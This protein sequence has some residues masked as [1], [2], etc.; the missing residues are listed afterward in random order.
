MSRRTRLAVVVG[1]CAA[2]AAAAA[3]G[4][5]LLQGDDGS[6]APAAATTANAPPPLE[7]DVYPGEP[8]A[9]VLRAAERAYDA[10]RLEVAATRFQRV[11]AEDPGS[12]RAAVG[13]AL[14]AWPE[15][16]VAELEAL[17]QQAP[18]SGLVRLYLG[19]ALSATGDDEAARRAWREAVGRDP[20]TPAAVRA[21]SLLHP[22]IAPGLPFFVPRAAPPERVQRLT[23]LE[24]L[25]ALQVLA[26]RGGAAEF[27]LLGSVLQRLGHPVSAREAFDRAVELAPGSVEARVAAAVGRFDKANPSAAF[28]RLGPLSR[29]HPRAAVV[30]LHLGV[31]LLWIRA[32]DEAERQLTRAARANPGSV[33]GREAE[34]LLATLAQG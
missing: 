27:L 33:Y 32:V 2:A 15:G 24:Q 13:A 18:S 17:A 1:L 22:D 21:D 19:L 28:S 31:M 16:T 9:E 34:K 11:L 23:A 29:D 4:G 26:E 25:R 5:A 8:N 10:G 3:I 30:R 6:A 12:L 7:L 14:A 20:D